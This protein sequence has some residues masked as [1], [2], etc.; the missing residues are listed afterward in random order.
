VLTSKTVDGSTV[1]NGLSNGTNNSTSCVR[2]PHLSGMDGGDFLYHLALGTATHNLVD[3]FGDVKFV[4]VGGTA[5]R[6]EAF[7]YFVGEELGIKLQTGVTL[8]DITQNAN[9]YSMYKV[10][11]VLSVT[12]GM[13]SP[14]LSI[15]LHE[16]LKLI[17]YAKCTDVVFLRIGT[18]GGL[19]VAAGSLVVT[20]NGVDGLLRPYLEMPVLGK[21]VRRPVVFDAKLVE[22]LVSIS[23]EELP[24]LNVV[25]GTTMCTSDFYEGQGRLDGAFCNYQESDKMNYLKTIAEA[26]VVNIEMESVTFGAMCHAAGVQAGIICVTLLDRLLGDQVLLDQFEYAE[27]QRRPQQLAAKLIKRRYQSFLTNGL[28][29][30]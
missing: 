20:S 4:C 15:L 30:K 18:S 22:E 23:R 2:N 27:Y 29:K 5:K 25:T 7:A 13:G 17:H 9:R 28:L 14:S 26:G 11:P 1:T 10:G 19:G 24:G 6:M 21:L 8:Q 16:L 12:H 3:M